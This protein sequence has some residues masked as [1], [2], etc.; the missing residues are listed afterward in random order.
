MLNS[1]YVEAARK[2][3]SIKDIEISNIKGE[4]TISERWED[5][6]IK[7]SRDNFSLAAGDGSFNKKKFL[8]FTFY[9]VGCESL[10]FNGELERAENAVIDSMPHH[11]F[12]DDLLRTF[13][14]ILELRYAIKSV[15][16]YEADYYLYDGSLF[17]DLIRPFPNGVSI[18]KKKQEEILDATI[19]DLT[20]KL[21]NFNARILA[22][23][24]IKNFY[25]SNVD[26]FSYTMFLS[27][28]EKLL[29]LKELLKYNKRI[30]AISKT[31]TNNDMF[32]SN[33]PDIAIFD[34]YTKKS[35]ISD[36]IYKKVSNEVKHKFPVEEEFFKNQEFT[37][38]YLRLDDYK[39]V[40]K[41][42]LPY[43]A[44]K[45]EVLDII[46]K[47]KKYS[48]DGYPYLLKKAHKDVV[49]S[50]KNMD[51]LALMMNV[52]EK[53]GREMLR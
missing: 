5:L 33:V 6:R 27:S 17:G 50:N 20:E 16:N 46:A 38:F 48:T 10:I 22:P 28:V 49:I 42:E 1:L 53:I 3:G 14:G 18:S 52:Y 7:P 43:R 41:V 21:L 31:S 12:T 29:L 47:I 40:I 15:D 11:E 24:I 23:D 4:S 8:S 34:K 25:K 39:N 30:I 44:T 35:G 32:K 36:L 19:D 13:M 51:E 37:I 9:A 2:K 26:L 45:D